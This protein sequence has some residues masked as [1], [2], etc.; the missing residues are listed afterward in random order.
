MAKFVLRPSSPR[1]T[2]RLDASGGNLCLTGKGAGDLCATTEDETE[3][4]VLVEAE[5]VRDAEA[6]AARHPIIREGSQLRQRGRD[7]SLVFPM[8]RPLTALHTTIRELP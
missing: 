2:F 5:C 8:R 6:L 3:N 4:V 1:P 7:G